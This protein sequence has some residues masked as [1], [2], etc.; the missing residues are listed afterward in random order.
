M[1]QTL[2]LFQSASRLSAALRGGQAPLWWRRGQAR[3]TAP[4][5]AMQR[6]CG[7]IAVLAKTHPLLSQ[8][9]LLG[10]CLQALTERRVAPSGAVTEQPQFRRP[11]LTHSDHY[12]QH[13]RRKESVSTPTATA[14]RSAM[15]FLTTPTTRTPQRP[16]ESWSHH[17]AQSVSQLQP[18]AGRSLL[19]RLAGESQ[20]IEISNRQLAHGIE[21]QPTHPALMSLPRSPKA[22]AAQDWLHHVAQRAER[23]LRRYGL[24]VSGQPNDIVAD[25]PGFDA[26]RPL[27]AQWAMALNGPAASLELLHYLASAEA[28]DA[29]TL[30]Q[31]ERER[32]RQNHRLPDA[33]GQLAGRS[34]RTFNQDDRLSGEENPI[35]VP[36]RASIVPTLEQS[37]ISTTKAARHGPTRAREM[38]ASVPS[39][40]SPASPKQTA[41]GDDEWEPP[42][43]V[44]PLVITPALSPL[45]PPQTL[46]EMTPPVA[47]SAAR[48]GARQDEAAARG[49]DLSV[50]AVQIKRILDEEARRHGIDV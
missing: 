9:P 5:S 23:A 48:Q 15:L 41:N 40:T 46:G 10:S 16:Q 11:R 43:R 1:S 24:D 7:W 26:A 8:Q 37:P 39:K 3:W 31:A 44:A 34:D 42:A 29:E 27:V 2:A 21:A 28:R 33:S 30:H 18:Q 19:S 12:L 50:L 17:P 20:A 14:S 49:E 45:L 38:S 36:S 13:N 25:R 47:A 35:P 32:A 4:L 22:M 6:S